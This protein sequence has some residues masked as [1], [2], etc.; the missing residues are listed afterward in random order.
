[1]TVCDRFLD[2][3]GSLDPTGHFHVGDADS[4]I[5]IAARGGAEEA[6]R[7]PYYNIQ[8]DGVAHGNPGNVNDPRVIE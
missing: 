3:I 2:P 4:D 1:M 6:A 8:G 7:A 5:R